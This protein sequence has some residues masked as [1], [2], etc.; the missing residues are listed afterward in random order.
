MPNL[1]PGSPNNVNATPAA[2]QVFTPTPGV[3]ASCRFY[4]PGPSTIY[5]GGQSVTPGNGLPI[6]P[7]N[8]PVELQ[9]VN[10]NL[11]ACSGITSVGA[12]TTLSG[13]SGAGS[14]GATVAS[15]VAA[16]NWLRIG[17]GTGIEYV[18]VATGT[19]VVT[20]TTSTLYDHASGATV[21]TVT[22]SPGPLSV[23]AGVI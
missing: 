19:T 23:Q 12:T 9:N 2:Q 5:V 17:N 8:R 7:G 20:F 14:T 22:A 3:Q 13:A 6:L 16:G 21:A 4:N 11:Y 1:P 18:Q 10:V 15:A